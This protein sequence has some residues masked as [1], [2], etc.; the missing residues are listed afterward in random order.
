MGVSGAGKSTIGRR[1]AAALG[2]PFHDA[3][4]FHPPEN[5]QKMSAGI[6]LNDTDRHPWLL[7]IRQR[8]DDYLKQS[9]PA[10][11]TCSALKASYRDLLLDDTRKIELVYLKGTETV[12][13][14]RLEQRQGH[15]MPPEMLRSQ[16]GTLETPEGALEVDIAQSPARIVRQ[17]VRRLGLERSA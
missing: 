5:I 7:A 2:W 17:I 14:E 16:L 10:I 13:R 8:I 3:D 9:T 4:D 11:F 1:L 15:F 6:P 12:L